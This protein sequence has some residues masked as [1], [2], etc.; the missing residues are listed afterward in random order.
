MLLE[1]RN[2]QAANTFRL[3]DCG[4]KYLQLRK[5]KLQAVNTFRLR[6]LCGDKYLQLKKR[7][8][9]PVTDDSQ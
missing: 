3:T 2:L 7:K 5:R 4:Y 9:R 8:L 6:A 1:K